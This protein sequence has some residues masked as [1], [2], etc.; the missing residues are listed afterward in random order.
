MKLGE[1]TWLFTEQ[2]KQCAGAPPGM[3]DF[4]DML[5]DLDGLPKASEKDKR[6]AL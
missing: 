6:F 5:W 3:E 2:C 1:D 4:D